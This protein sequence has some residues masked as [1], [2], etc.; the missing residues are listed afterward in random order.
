MKR[1]N[2]KR[3]KKTTR[4]IKREDNKDVLDLENINI[5]IID[6][7]QENIRNIHKKYGK[8]FIIKYKNNTIPVIL[9]RVI[10]DTYKEQLYCLYYDLEKRIDELI[11]FSIY[12]IDPLKSELNNN[13][14]I[15]DIHRTDEINGSTMVKIVLKINEVLK[16]KK[17]S[18][19]DATTIE[20]HNKIYD[21]SYFKLIEKGITFYMKFGFDFDMGSIDMFY[22]KFRSVDDLKSKIKEVID[23]IKLIKVKDII[24]E[25][26]STLDI[27]NEVVKKQDYNNFNIILNDY[28]SYLIIPYRRYYKKNPESSISELFRESNIMLNILKD[29]AMKYEYLTDFIIELF[30]NKDKCVLYD[31]ISDYIFYSDRYKIIYGKKSIERDYIGWFEYL[32]ILRSKM[33]FSYI[34]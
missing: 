12:F 29:N 14:Y 11:P 25:Y 10:L 22:T 17:T 6:D 5:E 26:Q 27:L 32:N 3:S 8:K 30:N 7:V 4:K 1:I 9:E 21:L 15:S 16:V 31:K 24:D 13:T 23:K 18:L 19:Y 28:N 34:F 2:K 20:C 33:I